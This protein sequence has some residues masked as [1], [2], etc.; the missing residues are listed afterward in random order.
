M[1]DAITCIKGMKYEWDGKTCKAFLLSDGSWQFEW[2]SPD[3]EAVKVRLSPMAV[4]TTV[5]AI[6][7]IVESSGKPFGW[8]PQPNQEKP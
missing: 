4:R 2:Q 1:S 7:E 5:R 8:E 6:S 3:Q